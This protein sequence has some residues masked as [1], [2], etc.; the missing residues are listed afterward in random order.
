MPNAHSTDTVTGRDPSGADW[1]REAVVYQVYPRSFADGN[2]D[3]IGD[4]RGV[5]SHLDHLVELGVDAVWFSPFYP[6]ALTDGGYDVDDYRDVDP[7][8]GTLE[9]FDE[10]VR[11]L[12]AA[13]IKVVIDI[14][15]NH[16]SDRHAWFREALAAGRGSRA[17]ERYVFREGRGENGE[18]PP[19]DWPAFFGGPAWT[20]VADG[21]W[22]LHLF[23]PHQPDWN[24]ADAEVRADFLR[25]LRFWADRGVAGFRVDAAMCLTKD[26]SEPLPDWDDVLPGFPALVGGADG[27]GEGVLFGEGQNPIYDRDD[28]Q[29]VYAEWR[30]LFDSYEPPRFAV[31][32]AWVAAHRRAR[33]A[34]PRSL[35]QVFN[36]DLLLASWDAAAFGE[37]IRQNLG[38]AEASGSSSTWVLSNHDMPRHATRLAAEPVSGTEPVGGTLDA[39]PPPGGTGLDRARAASMLILALPGSAYLYQ[40]EELGLPEVSLPREVAQDPVTGK[41]DAAVPSRDGCRVPLPWNTQAPFFGFSEHAAHLPQP[42]WFGDLSVALQ[43]GDPGSTL[44]LYRRALRIRRQLRTDGPVT[45][46]DLG[47]RLV[48]FTRGGRW[49]SVTNFGDTPAYLPPG[50]VLLSSHPL[51]DGMLPADSTAWL[52]DPATPA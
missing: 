6:S 13:G 49:T 21:Q 9:E 20:R 32:E 4:L 33:Y 46:L 41:E 31:A 16:S 14:V 39:P 1:W 24:W 43:S 37:V 8:I 17:R 29:E 22:Y 36:F 35:G 11:R 2:G 25:T 34:S 5:L 52:R 12:G 10:V 44:S 26:M 15:A 23:T 45:W 47:P 28:V 19:S 7:A 48:A 27:R 42:T 50:D 30:A 51:V 3:G 18:L 38:L 40:G